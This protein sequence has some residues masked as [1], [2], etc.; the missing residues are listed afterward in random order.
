VGGCEVR[1]AGAEPDDDAGQDGAGSMAGAFVDH[2]QKCHS[3]VSLWLTWKL[4]LVR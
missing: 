2:L 3:F 4:G 1:M